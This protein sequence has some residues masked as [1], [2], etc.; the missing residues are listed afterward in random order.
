MLN[1]N[2]IIVLINQQMRKVIDEDENLKDKID[3]QVVNEVEYKRNKKKDPNKVY[4]VVRFAQGNET[5]AYTSVPFT[6][7]S[8]GQM[9]SIELTQLLLMSYV[10]KYNLTRVDEYN[11]AQSYNTPNIVSNFNLVNEGMRSLFYIAGTFLISTLQNF[12][13][14]IECNGE[15]MDFITVQYDFSA[16][17][18]PAPYWGGNGYTKSFVK[19]GTITFN[20]VSFLTNKQPLNDMLNIATKNGDMNNA[21]VFKI[22][23]KNGIALNNVEFKM[24][25]LSLSQNLVEVPAVTITFTM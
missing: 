12:V 11:L 23:F 16:S 4:M 1:Y 25:G 19:Q 8:M 6:M 24:T 20:I 9:N 7:V 17:P 10:T 2:D 21:F 5:F 22:K 14:S 18:E 13:E 3:I 15:M